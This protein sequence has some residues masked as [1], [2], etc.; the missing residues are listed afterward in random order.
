MIDLK[1]KDN[2][3]CF[4][5][6]QLISKDECQSLIEYINQLI[7]IV[8]DDD[9]EYKYY[10]YKSIL[11]KN[12][13]FELQY[14]KL[15]IFGKI[16]N[17]VPKSLIHEGDT[18]HLIDLADNLNLI[19]YEEGGIFEIHRDYLSGGALSKNFYTVNL[20]LNDIIFKDGGYLNLYDD[21]YSIKYQITP[22][23]G[24]AIIFDMKTYHE[25]QKLIKGL[26]YFMKVGIKYKLMD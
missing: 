7:L 5:I 21:E 18:Y 24:R 1:Y 14:L 17:Y 16:C 15:K 6:N 22:E 8:E 23:S 26:K 25:S 11:W 4:Q 2:Q 3:I 10:E 20:Y 12:L 9:R 13:P 19:K